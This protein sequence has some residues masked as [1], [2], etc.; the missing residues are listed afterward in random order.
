M[1]ANTIEENKKRAVFDGHDRLWLFGYGSLIFKAD[2]P[3]LETRP[4]QISGWT[5]RFWQGSHDHRGT[6]EAPGRVATLIAE[7]AA[8][9]DGLAYHITPDVF[10][11]LDYREKNGYLRF[12][13]TLTF[14]DQ[15]QA[16]G[17]VYIAT[18]D[19]TAFLGPASERDI[20]QYIQHK[21]GPSGRNAD[22]LKDLAKALRA[23]NA[24]DPH[25][26][27]IEEHLLVLEQEGQ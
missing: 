19:N 14:R 8:V 4:A 7:E 12:T 9:C 17:L 23:L 26:F 20:A 13:T 27:G 2:F 21:E 24:H 18:E 5:R 6:H 3:F 22:Y 10:D 15:Q 11:H 16:E 1:S 25:V